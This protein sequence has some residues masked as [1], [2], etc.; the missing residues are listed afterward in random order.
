MTALVGVW[1]AGWLLTVLVE[2][3][4]L[5][6]AAWL[7]G[8]TLLRRHPARREFVW[9]AAVTVVLV[10]P[11]LQLASGRS[12][13]LGPVFAEA[14]PVEPAPSRPSGG[15]GGDTGRVGVL[16]AERTA[17]A[18]SPRDTARR[19]LIAGW[20]GAEVPDEPA[21]L[22]VR[23]ALG[24]WLAGALLGVLLLL[25]RHL[26]FHRSVG[27][28]RPVPNS[29]V[30]AVFRE[31]V[32]DRP[33]L[34]GVRLTHSPSLP[35]PAT[36]S[37]REICVPWPRF[38]ALDLPRQRALLAHELAHVE[39]NDPAW[40][41]AAELLAAVLWFQPLLRVARRELRVASELLADRR[42]VVWTRAPAAMAAALGEVAAWVA[43]GRQ[44]CAVGA[45]D[46]GSSLVRRVRAILADPTTAPSGWS[47]AV[48]RALAVAALT[49]VVLGLPALSVVPVDPEA[50]ATERAVWPEAPPGPDVQPSSADTA[51][52]PRPEIRTL[53]LG[54]GP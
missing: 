21:S 53:V 4:L 19:E 12:V 27:P 51:A 16:P 30:M 11:L 47:P 9:R 31:L 18:G 13:V 23:S 26:R 43:P 40:R 8:R 36:L 14:P 5:L 44:G 17:T 28:R 25:V 39:R 33:A 35:A 38:A 45:A 20:G 29:G 15:V 32:R 10:A 52:S 42:A 48:R 46:S 7:A 50:P 41:W 24:T 3:T 49:G 22:A 37:R 54:G 1:T 6:G 2:G 34:A